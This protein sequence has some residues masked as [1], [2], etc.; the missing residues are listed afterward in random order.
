VP[1]QIA[2]ACREIAGAGYEGLSNAAGADPATG[3]ILGSMVGNYNCGAW[4]KAAANND[5]TLLISPGF[6]PTIQLI[7]ALKTYASGVVDVTPEAM[8]AN[9]VKRV[10]FT[11]VTIR[12]GG[13]FVPVGVVPVVPVGGTPAKVLDGA[14]KTVQQRVNQVGKAVG[15][16][17]VWDARRKRTI[18]CPVHWTC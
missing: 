8:L 18:R 16:F 1:N 11:L 13:A 10:D 15:E 17:L 14:Q 9:L 2:A 4:F 5:P 7:R 12:I 6:V 3:P